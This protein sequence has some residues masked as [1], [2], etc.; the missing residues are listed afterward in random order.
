M[1][2]ASFQFGDQDQH[3]CRVECGYFGSERYYVDDVLVLRHWSFTMGGARQFDAAGHRVE[4]RIRVGMHGASG[5]AYVDGQLKATDL[6]S[7][8]NSALKSRRERPA[9]SWHGLVLWVALA[10]VLV[11]AFRRCSGAA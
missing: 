7:A 4:L 8:F 2:T 3:S 11:F 10:G 9:S 6:F 5:D 1:P